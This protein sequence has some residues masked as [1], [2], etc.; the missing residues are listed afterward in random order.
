MPGAKEVDVVDEL[1]DVDSGPID[2]TEFGAEPVV[3]PGASS[4]DRTTTTTTSAAIAMRISAMVGRRIAR[5]YRMVGLG[6]QLAQ[7]NRL[8]HDGA[9]QVG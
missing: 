8:G 1:D 4:D 3:R 6:G 5:G 2:V 7:R 9:L